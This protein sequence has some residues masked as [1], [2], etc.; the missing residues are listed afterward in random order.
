MKKEGTT[1]RKEGIRQKQGRRKKGKTGK[2]GKKGRTGKK[3]NEIKGNT[4]KEAKEGRIENKEKVNDK[5]A[6]YIKLLL[7]GPRIP[8]AHPPMSSTETNRIK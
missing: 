7:I 1:E 5:I 6:N 3:T 4:G 2:K 8:V